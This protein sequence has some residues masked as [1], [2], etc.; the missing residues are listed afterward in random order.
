D[1]G[2][3]VSFPVPEGDFDMT[4]SYDQTWAVE[5][6]I[7]ALLQADSTLWTNING[8][9]YEGAI[10]KGVA[11]RQPN[12]FA[13]VREV[14]LADA[15]LVMHDVGV[16]A[17]R[18]LLAW[19]IYDYEV[20]VTGETESYG[21]L[22]AGNAGRVYTDLH[23]TQGTVDGNEVNLFVTGTFKRRY[24]RDGRVFK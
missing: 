11:T 10:P 17:N 4:R 21:E 5:Q 20:I 19:N 24:V 1:V 14:A 18:S 7:M 23:N 12:I 15:D 13:I 8:Q 9:F 22:L 16:A 2:D 6:Q 3:G